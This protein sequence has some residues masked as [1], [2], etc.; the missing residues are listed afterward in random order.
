[1]VAELKQQNQFTK[2]PTSCLHIGYCFDPE[3]WPGLLYGC[4]KVQNA[5]VPGRP[6][7]NKVLVSSCLLGNAVRY[8]GGDLKADHVVLKRWVDAGVVVSFCPEVAAGLPT[9]RAPAEIQGGNGTS[10]LDRSVPIL[11]VD[12]ADVT[13]AFF[14][15]ARKALEL[16]RA[17]DISVAVLTDGS[18]SCGSSYI[19]NGE[20]LGK[21]IEGHGVTTALLLHH[22]VKV[23]SQ[24]QLDDAYSYFSSH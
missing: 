17:H 13:D 2:A 7:M 21:K 14:R 11:N 1:M 22:G 15:G 5:L 3:T 16:C 8:D 24:Y 20:F 4:I 6:A 12:G 23:F 9:P 10:V 18:P 19:Y